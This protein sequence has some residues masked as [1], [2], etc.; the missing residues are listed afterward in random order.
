MSFRNSYGWLDRCLHRLAFATPSAQLG[1]ADMERR[2]FRRELESLRAERPLFVTGLPRAGTTILLELLSRTPSVA[3]HT[4]RDMPFVLAPLM[5]GGFARR[6]RRSDAPRERAH[7]DGI[8]VS[9]DSP[10]AFEEVVWMAFHRD[11]YRGLSIEPWETL[12]DDEFAS[13]FAEHMRKVVALRRRDKPD[14]ARYASKN[15]LNIARMP[16]LLERFDDAIA[17]VP[18]RAPL[19]HAASLLRQHQRFSQMHA[20]DTFARRYMGGIGHFDF[21]DNLKPVDFGGWL[22]GRDASAADGLTFWLEYWCAAYRSLLRAAAHSRLHLLSFER[23]GAAE[24]LHALAA[25]T[26]LDPADLTA[27]A[28]ILSPIQD[29]AVDASGVPAALLDEAAALHAQLLTRCLLRS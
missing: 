14:A 6:F 10:E 5:W 4:Y 19:Q 29:R 24:G 23:L 20:A 9:M 26:A 16:A 12:E 7:G 3:T 25:A 1:V 18:F 13:F 8:Q 15:N 2:I 21:G 11:R 28:G 27:H 22:G 17:L